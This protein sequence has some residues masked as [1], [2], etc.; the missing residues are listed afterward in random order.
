MGEFGM[1]IKSRTKIKGNKTDQAEYGWYGKVNDRTEGNAKI[2]A[3]LTVNSI[4]YSN[5]WGGLIKGIYGIIKN[6]C[7]YIYIDEGDCRETFI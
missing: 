1:N 2:G 4:I 5:N 6:F 3:V 7:E